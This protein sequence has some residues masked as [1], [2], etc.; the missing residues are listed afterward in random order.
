MTEKKEAAAGDANTHSGKNHYYTAIV[1]EKERF[2]KCFTT[3]SVRSA[4]NYF[5]RRK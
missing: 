5:P 3:E 2:V 4:V 1:A